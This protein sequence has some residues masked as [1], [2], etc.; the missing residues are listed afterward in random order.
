MMRGCDVH[1]RVC[2]AKICGK[3]L[4]DEGY[5]MGEGVL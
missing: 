2:D 3:R 4:C 5:T 1:E